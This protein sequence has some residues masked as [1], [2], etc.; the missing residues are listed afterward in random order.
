[1]VS[2][3]YKRKM[4]N[5][6]VMSFCNYSDYSNNKGDIINMHSLD[7]NNCGKVN[8]LLLEQYTYE[9][10][11][12]DSEEDIYQKISKNY[13]YEIRRANKEQV[14]YVYSTSTDCD[15]LDEFENVYNSM[16][17]KKRLHNR[18]NR[19]MII[20]GLRTGN[21]LLSK[22]ESE[23]SSD[24][25]VFHAYLYDSERAVLLYSASPLWSEEDKDKT[26]AIGRLNKALHWKDMC[27]FRNQGLEVYEWGGIENP[28]DKNGIAQFKASFGGEL[29]K[30]CNYTIPTNIRGKI[31][32]QVLKF[33]RKR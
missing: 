24:I 28:D 19:G 7:I 23:V 10:C 2:Y 9:N 25:K 5:V 6:G 14:E 29:K 31:Y 33:L 17:E 8:G 3:T 22:A 4:F 16:F 12:T 11:L 21:I 30:Y 13:R 18:F 27:Y 20:G 15:F 26:A 1:M 32:V